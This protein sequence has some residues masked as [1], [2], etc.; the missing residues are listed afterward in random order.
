MKKSNLIIVI[1]LL[2]ITT[3]FTV[4]YLP[5][6]TAS[7]PGTLTIT[8]EGKDILVDPFKA[9]AVDVQGTTINGKGKE[10]VISDT[11]VTLLSVLNLA[12]ITLDDF[13]VAKIVSTD[14]YSAELTAD[15]ISSD[16]VAYLISSTDDAGAL[17]I[18]LVVFGDSN[19]KRQVK[20]VARIELKK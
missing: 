18:K 6:R 1:V 16:G 19:S 15:E 14:E 4:I 8:Y 7:A 13:S 9:P 5:S 11:G 20:D 12:D 2:L 17:K 3:V 10:N